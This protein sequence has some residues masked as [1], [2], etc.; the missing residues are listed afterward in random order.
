MCARITKA[1][2]NFLSD[3]SFLTLEMDL[4]LKGTG[5]IATL[6]EYLKSGKI[7]KKNILNSKK[8]C[9]SFKKISL[10][11]RESGQTKQILWTSATPDDLYQQLPAPARTEEELLNNMQTLTVS[12]TKTFLVLW[13]KTCMKLASKTSLHLRR[14]LNVVL[15]CSAY[16]QN[17]ILIL[18]SQIKGIFAKSIEGN[19]L[20]ATGRT[21]LRILMTKSSALQFSW[22]GLKLPERAAIDQIRYFVSHNGINALCIPTCQRKRYCTTFE[23]EWKSGFLLW[24]MSKEKHLHPLR[25]WEELNKAIR[26]RYHCFFHLWIGQTRELARIRVQHLETK[27]SFAMYERHCHLCGNWITIAKST[28]WFGNTTRGIRIKV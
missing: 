7:W 8:I 15:L 3:Q 10:N 2:C 28:W 19:D 12:L 24:S 22:S 1:Y 11:F 23:T 26:F 14:L 25:Q 4:Q 21:F 5:A 27:Q 13:W 17:S 18:Q 20:K 6:P 9:L 16:F